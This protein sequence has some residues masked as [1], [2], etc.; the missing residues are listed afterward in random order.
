MDAKIGFDTAEDEPSKVGRFLI[1]IGGLSTNAFFHALVR[2]VTLFFSGAVSHDAFSII[3]NADNKMRFRPT[4][5]QVIP[6]PFAA[7]MQ[8]GH[9]EPLALW[10]WEQ[11]TF[12][13]I[14]IIFYQCQ[15]WENV[16]FDV[17]SDFR[18]LTT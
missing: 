9:P 4:C 10:L 14:C 3:F 15:I 7:P 13:T 12:F 6:M 18:V 1:G 8:Q 17:V 5:Q 2:F 11:N 16:I